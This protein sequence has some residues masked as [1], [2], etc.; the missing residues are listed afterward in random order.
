MRRGEAAHDHFLKVNVEQE[1]FLK[2]S[3]YS[4]KVLSEE[5]SRRVE[6]ENTNNDFLSATINIYRTMVVVSHRG[7]SVRAK[8]HTHEKT[9]YESFDKNESTNTYALA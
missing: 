5:P 7:K 6:K 4:I 1:I 3:T 2:L 8:R 9:I